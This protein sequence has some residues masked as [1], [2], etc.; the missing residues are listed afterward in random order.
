MG[1]RWSAIYRDLYMVWDSSLCPWTSNT[2]PPAVDEVVCMAM[3]SKARH[4][5]ARQGKVQGKVG[6]SNAMQCQAR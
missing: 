6:H 1:Y 2:F 3:Q 4:A 5:N